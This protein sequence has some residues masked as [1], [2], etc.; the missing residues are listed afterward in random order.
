MRT[1]FEHS[2]ERRFCKSGL[3]ECIDAEGENE[4]VSILLVLVDEKTFVVRDVIW[5]IASD[6][7]MAKFVILLV[8]L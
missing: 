4:I 8:I 7:Q 2:R 5:K 1:V 3:L 6:N